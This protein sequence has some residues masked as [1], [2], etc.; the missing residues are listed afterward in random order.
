MHDPGFAGWAAQVLGATAVRVL[1]DNA[2]TKDAHSG[3]ELRWH[4]DYAYWPLGQPNA[5]TVW[6]A[7]DDV[8]VANGAV[9]MARGQPP[10]RRTPAGGVRHRGVVLR[11]SGG[12][13]SCAP[14]NDPADAGLDVDVIELRGR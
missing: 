11:A 1:E 3:G 12:R 2:L 8:T 4:Q 13:P 5:V 6:I 9:R 14:I 10:P 7:L